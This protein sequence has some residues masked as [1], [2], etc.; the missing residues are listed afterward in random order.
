MQY[1][2]FTSQ[3]DYFNFSSEL[4]KIISCLRQ[5][6]PCWPPSLSFCPLSGPAC[7]AATTAATG[8]A[9]PTPLWP[10]SCG[11]RARVT[12]MFRR[13]D[14]DVHGKVELM[15]KQPQLTVTRNKKLVRIH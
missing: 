9:A 6:S 4:I 13:D 3:V 10:P 2:I 1:K 11:T 14:G 5:R 15:L 12:R 7:L 8:P